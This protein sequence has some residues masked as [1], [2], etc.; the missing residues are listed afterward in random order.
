MTQHL[1]KIENWDELANS[2]NSIAELKSM[3]NAANARQLRRQALRDL[4]M[5][6]SEW[7][8]RKKAEKAQQML[9]DGEQVKNVARA[10]GYTHLP[11]FSLYF[12]KRTGMSPREF[13]RR[14]S[15]RATRS[16]LKATNKLP[17]R[18]T[19]SRR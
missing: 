12:V 16:N 10:L 6:T 4:G 18:I 5:S 15:K 9:R 7:L 1:K 19:F 8:A 14:N 3:I 2:A 11:N 13:I 17:S